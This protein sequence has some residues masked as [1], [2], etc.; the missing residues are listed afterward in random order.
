[1]S[2]SL[3]AQFGR[4]FA[5]IRHLVRKHAAALWHGRGRQR[6]PVLG[7]RGRLRGR[8]GRSRGCLPNRGLSLGW[9]RRLAPVAKIFRH[10]QRHTPPTSLSWICK[11]DAQASSPG[12]SEGHAILH[13]LLSSHLAFLRLACDA[14]L[15]RHVMRMSAPRRF[16]SFHCAPYTRVHYAA[17]VWKYTPRT[18]SGTVSPTQGIPASSCWLRLMTHR[19]R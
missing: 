8:P 18:P 19:G 6:C 1:M 7:C 12:G 16:P 17:C 15:R 4:A 13:A 9:R 14:G 3:L 10:Y 11:C 2:R 5:I